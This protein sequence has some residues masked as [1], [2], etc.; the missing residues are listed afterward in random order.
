M[1]TRLRWRR[2]RHPPLDPTI[3]G[4]ARHHRQLRT[5]RQRRPGGRC[6]LATPDSKVLAN[7]RVITATRRPKPQL[8]HQ[9]VPP[10]LPRPLR[11]SR[12]PTRQHASLSLVLLLRR[13]RQRHPRLLLLP[14]LLGLRLRLGLGPRRRERRRHFERGWRRQRRNMP[15]RWRAFETWR[16][17]TLTL[18]RQ[19]R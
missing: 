4:R 11:S 5:A 9:L 14:P 17:T 7:S 16:K 15:R 2:R 3:L 1:G 12:V 10:L 19:C 8:H 13:S 18:R 6:R